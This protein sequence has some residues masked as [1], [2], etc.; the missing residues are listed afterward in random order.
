MNEE[1]TDAVEA[2]R[3]RVEQ[4]TTAIEKASLAEYVE[5]V[6]RPWWM[7]YTNFIAGLSRGFGTAIGFTLLGAILLYV[8]QSA[9]IRNIP[10]VGGFI[11][12][13]VRVVQYD[14]R[15]R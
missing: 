3:V 4:L 13:L 9:F 7:I 2:L 11:A 10:V 6:R 8:L 5:L 14:L 15:A 1:R 12:D